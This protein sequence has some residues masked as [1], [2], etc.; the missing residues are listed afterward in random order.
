MEYIKRHIDKSLE[1]WKNSALHKPLLLRGARQVGKSSSVRELGK[2][3]EYFLEINFENKDHKKAKKIF[4]H[5]SSPKIIT[6]ELYSMFG[7][8]VEAEKTL[9]FLDEIQSCVDAIS[10]L[11]FFYEQMPELHV[12]AAGSLL[13]FALEELPSYGVGRI[14]SRFMYPLSFG[15]YL[16]AIKMERLAE[17]VKTASPKNPLSEALHHTALKHLINHIVIGGMPEVVAAYSRGETLAECMQILNDLM[18]TYYD[19]FA[20]YRKKTSALLLRRA[21]KSIVEQT[22][23]KFSYSEIS[24][25]ERHETLKRSVE[26]LVRAGLAYPQ[27]MTGGNGIPLGAEVNQKFCRFLI[28]DTGI[29][30]RILGEDISNILL[31]ETLEQINKGDVAE[32]FAGL[33]LLKNTPAN[34]SG[35]LYYW[36]RNERG[37]HAEVDFLIQKNSKIIPVEVKSGTTGKMQSLHLFMKEKQSEYG[38]RTSLENFAEYDKIKVYPL[39]AL[40]N[41]VSD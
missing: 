38:V 27:N 9:L 23:S 35:E 5:S 1:E 29:M 13:E 12:I 32:L 36:Q 26:L 17:T 33:E 22:G 10:A 28:F 4:E 31:G 6:D 40:G 19:D 24:R 37:S 3:F 16:G 8:P 18:H 15:E 21:L 7:I 34:L 14:T 39:Y 11:R 41:L 30:L 25:Q 2:Q 20:K